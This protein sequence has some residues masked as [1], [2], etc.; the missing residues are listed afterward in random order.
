MSKV[1]TFSHQQE[2]LS[3]DA[4][5]WTRFPE[6]Q[7][8]IPYGRFRNVYLYINEQCQLQCSHCYMGERLDRGTMMS[9]EQACSNLLF[10][11]KMGGSKLT[12]LGGEATLHPDFEKILKFAYQCGYEKLILTTN[13]LYEAR[14]KLKNIEPSLFSY[15]QVSLDGAYPRTHDVIRGKGKFKI[16][17]ETTKELCYRGFDTRIICTVNKVNIDECLDLLPMADS[18]GVSLVKYHVFSS[19]GNGNEHER[20]L[21]NPQDWIKFYKSLKTEQKRYKTRIWYQPTYALKEDVENFVEQGYRGCIGRTMDRISV[22]PDGKAYICSYL[23]DTDMNFGEMKDG[24]VVLNP[25]QNE[26]DLFTQVLSHPACGDC[27]I[28]F[29]CQG[30]C[31]AEKL[32]MGSSSCE[33]YDNIIPVCRLWK[34]DA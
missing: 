23:F 1:N 5:G 6:T 13:G 18:I 33:I 32:V 26:F 22:F 20:W 27:K 12:I 10:W 15:I 25:K 29:G 34:S 8:R 28:P 14:K 31:P 11:R 16:A 7:N 4:Y 9:Y 19:I 30:G 2:V 3:D 17:L 24:R 21:V